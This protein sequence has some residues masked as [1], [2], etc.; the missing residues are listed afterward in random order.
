LGDKRTEK[1]KRQKKKTECE[2]VGRGKGLFKRQMK[3]GT[4]L[5][6]NVELRRWHR[7]GFKAKKLLQMGTRPDGFQ[8]KKKPTK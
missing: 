1:G 5:E 4:V 3:T 2:L 8:R 6:N 7:V